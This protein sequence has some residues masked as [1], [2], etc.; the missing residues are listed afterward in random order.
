MLGK[1]GFGLVYLAHDEQLQRRVAIKVP[2]RDRVSRPEHAEAYLAEARMLAALNH[3]HIVRVYDV[4]GTDDFPFF[5]VS[6]YIAGSTLAQRIKDGPLAWL[7]AA[8]LVATVAEALHYA[9]RQGLV[10]RDVKPG[11]ILLDADGKPVVVDL[12]LALREAHVG[13][14]PKF[15]GTPSYM[16]PEQARG[17]G[18]RV[19]GRSDIFSLGVVLYQML[20][21]KLPFKGDSLNDLL[22]AIT[23][24]EPR[25]PRQYNDGIPKELERICFK[26]LAKRCDRTLLDRRGLGRGIY[27]PSWPTRKFWRQRPYGSKALP[28]RQ[29]SCRKRRPRRRLSGAR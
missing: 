1:G 16:S 10:H 29:W 22:Q 2:H 23:S 28:P 15:A 6:E 3:P 25:P 24:F 17:E 11:N 27:G 12:G 8:E 20:A 19:D 13:H 9:H 14:G 7:E 26:A 5:I 21:G 4:G 18:H